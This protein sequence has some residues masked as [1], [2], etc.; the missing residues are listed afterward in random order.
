M[1]SFSVYGLVII[2]ILS[3]FSVFAQDSKAEKTALNFASKQI[4]PGLYMIEG[5]GGFTGGNIAL[6]VGKDGVV[7]IDD[8]MPPLLDK[9]TSAIKSITN[10]PVDFLINTHFHGDHAGNNQG[11]ADMGTKI[12][13][14]ENTRKNLLASMKEKSE[15]INEAALPVFTFSDEMHFYLNDHDA[16]II[17]VANAHTDGDAII[18]YKNLNVIHTGDTMF[19]GMFP[20]IDYK[21]GGSIGGYIAAQKKVL[22]LSNDHTKIIPGHGELANKQDL[23]ASIAMLEESKRLIEQL[24][25]TGKQEEDIVKLNPLAKFHNDWHWSFITTE[26]MTRQLYKSLKGDD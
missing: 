16:Q 26:R 17:H 18:Y 3:A 12:F 25:A 20:Y 4:A 6:S 15:D 2:S 11:M 13:A 8:S 23:I 10:K 7:M 1:K 5:V 19:N 14:H 22:A 21:H 24:I 9:M